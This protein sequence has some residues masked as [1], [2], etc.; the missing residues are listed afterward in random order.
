MSSK[1]VSQG[2][3]SLSL[4][5]FKLLTIIVNFAVVVLVPIF[6]QLL[7]VIF[8]NYLSCIVQHPFQLIQV[9]ITI[10]IP[11]QLKGRLMHKTNLSKASQMAVV[12]VVCL[13]VTRD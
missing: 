9:N 5:Q 6:H 12:E 4:T 2:V 10:C 11:A 3:S 1:Q 8:G 13:S 7:N